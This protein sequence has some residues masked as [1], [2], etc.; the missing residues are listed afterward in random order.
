[1][2]TVKLDTGFNIEV[3]FPVSP[4]SRRLLAWILDTAL[5]FIYIWI[6]SSWFQL[7]MSEHP[8]LATLTALPL[9]LYYPVV[10]ILTNGH[11]A[12][13]KLMGIRIITLEGGQAS[14]SQYLLRWLLGIIDMP[15]WIFV[16]IYANVLPW[17]C[18]ILCFSGLAC[19]LISGKS[20]RIG[21]LVAGTI[22][23]YTRGRTSWQDTVFTQLEAGYR[24]KYPE[25]MR[26][27]DKD[28]NSL[29]SI[30]ELSKKSKDETM[31]YRIADRITSKLGIQTKEL[32][33]DFL[34]T[35][36]KDYNYYTA[37]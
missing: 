16:S 22:V 1:L 15:Y 12:G 11:T 14:I 8:V 27:S 7:S 24:P 20:Q 4:F 36:L 32:P 33:L 21:D 26:I 3:S 35:L 9:F 34:E 13:K 37:S 23:I 10:E 5:L 6:L 19:M 30:I 25:V 2:L 28:I 18:S 29:K 17:Y 31:A